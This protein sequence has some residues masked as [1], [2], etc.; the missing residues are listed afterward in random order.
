MLHSRVFGYSKTYEVPQYLEEQESPEKRK[1]HM[2]SD[3]FGAGMY[4][5]RNLKKDQE[6]RPVHVSPYESANSPP[7]YD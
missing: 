7:D 1:N 5:G 3:L 2:Y 4:Q 6:L